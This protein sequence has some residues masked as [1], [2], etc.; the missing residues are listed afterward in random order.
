MNCCGC[1]SRTASTKPLSE[2]FF[3]DGLVWDKHGRLYGSDGGKRVF[4]TPRPETAP[5]V[6]ASG[7]QSASGLGLAANGKSILVADTKAGTI[8]ALPTGVPGQ[9]VD[10]R[11]LPIKAAVAFPRLKWT[12]WEPI[13]DS[14]KMTALRPI[15]LTHAGDGSNRVFVAMQRGVIHVFPN[16]QQATKTSIFLD[17]HDRVFYDD[18]ENEQG[19]LGLVFHPKYKKNGEFFVFYTR[20]KD[21]KINV[22]S[23]F[24]VRRDDPNRADPDS[25]EELFRINRPFWNHDGGT[26]C[27]GPDGYLYVA[28]GDGGLANDPFGNGQNLKSL[29]GKILRLDVDQKSKS[30]NYSIPRTIPSWAERMLGRRSG[31]MVYATSGAWRSIAKPACCGRPTW[32]RTSMRRSI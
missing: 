13:S 25:E 8:T 23:R 6:L 17:I 28:L 32:D 9:E 19:F 22:L 27:F 10:E 21:K 18:K 26:I 7:F 11:P 15:V 12:G 4:V 30:F 24:R 1:G 3:L 2:P 29:L 14:G 5:V 20:K 16:D 31:P